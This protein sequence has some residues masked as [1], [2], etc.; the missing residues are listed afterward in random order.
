[1]FISTFVTVP[2]MSP[3]IFTVV[4]DFFPPQ[5]NT[6]VEDYAPSVVQLTFSFCDVYGRR[7]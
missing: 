4:V 1:M 2:V 7:I 3:F 5:L 6:N